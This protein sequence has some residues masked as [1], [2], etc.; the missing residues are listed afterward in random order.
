MEIWDGY[1][2]DGTLAGIDL[3][4]GKAIPEG[5]YHIVSEIMVRHID[6]SYLVMQR[7]LNK[8]LFPGQ[9]EASAGGSIL[10][11]ESPYQGAVR[12]LFE[13]TGIKADS[14]RH[15]YTVVNDNNKTI[16]VGFFC[17][18]DYVKDAIILQEGETISYRW[19]KKNDFFDFIK[20]SEFVSYKRQRW[21][22]YIDTL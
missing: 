20:T 8:P 4:R 6:G 9:Y 17:I 11:G 10:K 12:E 22:P 15:I 21:E 3:I 16:Y 18:T 19:L 1:S 2:K 14:L 7:D 5:V 13:E